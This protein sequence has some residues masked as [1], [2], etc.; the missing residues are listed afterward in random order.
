MTSDIRALL[1]AVAFAQVGQAALHLRAMSLL[2]TLESSSHVSK[3]SLPAFTK[4][5]IQQL[6]DSTL[7]NIHCSPEFIHLVW[8]LSGGWPLYAE[9]VNIYWKSQLA[10]ANLHDCSLF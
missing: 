7:E 4:D 8:E 6:A 1:F 3:L 10:N 2:G 9:Q 5:E